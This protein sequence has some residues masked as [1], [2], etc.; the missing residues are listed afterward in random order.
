M[1]LIYRL[2]LQEDLKNFGLYRDVTSSH[3]LVTQPSG[4][5][6]NNQSFGKVNSLEVLTASTGNL[7][8]SSSN[9]IVEI[10][11]VS[12]RKTNSYINIKTSVLEQL[13]DTFSFALWL[14]IDSWNSNYESYVYCGTGSN[15][16]NGYIFGLLRSGSSSTVNFIIGNGTSST[17]LNCGSGTLNVNKWY[18][19]IGTYENKIMKIYV[20]GA[21][22]TEYI[23]N[24]VPDFTKATVFNLGAMSST[25]Y[26]TDCSICDFR[27]YSHCL[28]SIE[29]RL[30]SQGLIVHFPLNREGFGQDNLAT[31]DTS[32]YSLDSGYFWINENTLEPNTTYTFS[33]EIESEDVDRC[34]IY[35]YTDAESTGVINNSFLA[36]GERHSWTFTTTD[37][38][39]GLI[40]YAGA[41][42]SNTI[43]EVT[44]KNIKIEEGKKQTPYVPQGD[45]LLYIEKGFDSKIEYDISGFNNDGLR[46]GVF[47]WVSDSPKLS[48]SQYFNGVD[49]YIAFPFNLNSA[50]GYTI[51]CWIYNLEDDPYWKAILIDEDA[52]SENA[53]KEIFDV[54]NIIKDVWIH[55]CITYESG[56]LKIYKN[57]KLISTNTVEETELNNQFTEGRIGN[58]IQPNYYWMGKICD[59]RVYATALSNSDVRFLYRNSKTVDFNGVI[60]GKIR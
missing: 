33:A 49:N 23:M 32:E 54:D 13:D 24:I 26:Q 58:T 2:P 47:K 12:G 9:D 45:E 25:E 35:N 52:E 36:D 50:D 48:V 42:D 51:A 17:E 27:L 6:G 20:D 46:K 18:H 15:E 4:K 3:N 59:V 28:T 16:L 34:T 53:E 56:I 7:I 21:L 38:A 10:T 30:L 8:T 22:I 19:I 43:Q 5:V 11:N 40:G 31:C 29:A 1:G 44:Y 60:N 57:G 55:V 39:I 41:M 14:R 37:G